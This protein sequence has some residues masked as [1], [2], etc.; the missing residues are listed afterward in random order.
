[1]TA[2]QHIAAVNIGGTFYTVLVRPTKT[3]VALKLAGKRLYTAERLM[4]DESAFL[5][6]RPDLT[7]RLLV[8]EVVNL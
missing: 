8:G 3:G 1:M 6:T 4:E 2:Y 7:A 5:A